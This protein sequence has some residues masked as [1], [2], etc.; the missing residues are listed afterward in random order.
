MPDLLL[1]PVH[2]FSSLGR[3]NCSPLETV[4]AKIK[5]RLAL[6]KERWSSMGLQSAML[7]VGE[8]GRPASS[9]RAKISMTIQH[10][11]ENYR[12]NRNSALGLPWVAS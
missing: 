7:W 6:R 8:A 12:K 3:L 9:P 11:Q 5:E 10:R 2:P 4:K 1:G